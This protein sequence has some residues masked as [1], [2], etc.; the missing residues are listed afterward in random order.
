MHGLLETKKLCTA[1]TTFRSVKL[2]TRVA[3]TLCLILTFLVV[4]PSSV[5]HAAP[6][7][8]YYTYSFYV[9]SLSNSAAYNLG[10]QQGIHDVRDL[11]GHQDSMVILDFG[12]PTYENGGYGTYYF[13]PAA[14][15]APLSNVQQVAEWFGIGF[16]DGLHA[17]GTS[18][19]DDRL[20][21]AIGTNNLGT[22]TTFRNH[23]AA[24]ARM[25]DTV[26]Q[27]YIQSGYQN[28]VVASG[29]N[30]AELDYN[31]PAQT[32][33]WADGYASANVGELWFDFGDSAACPTTGDGT[34]SGP[35]NGGWTQDSL[36]YFAYGTPNA[37]PAPEIYTPNGVQAQQWQKISLYAAVTKAGAMRF[38]SSF[39]QLGSCQQQGNP[40]SGVNNSPDTGFS[41]LWDTLFSDTRTAVG[42]S[43]STDIRYQ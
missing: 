26:E 35:C 28:N 20:T 5:T 40:C 27:F 37:Y 36:W 3:T 38:I 19:N 12:Q 13:D 33:P 17:M 31:G 24:W 18:T 10:Y 9:T 29:A 41:Q 6:T 11:P 14:D 15:F 16:F 42:F 39:T 22:R 30:D 23:G 4:T 1:R 43:W 2:A 7:P 34:T 21:I 32:T 8:P 25:V